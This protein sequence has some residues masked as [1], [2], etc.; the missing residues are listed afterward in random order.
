NGFDDIDYLKN[1]EE[2]ITTFAQTRPF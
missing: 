2:E 1:I